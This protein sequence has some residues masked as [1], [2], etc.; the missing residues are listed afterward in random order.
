[1]AGAGAG[2]DGG[3]EGAGG[4]EPGPSNYH[5]GGDAAFSRSS[6]RFDGSSPRPGARDN[7]AVRH[8][9]VNERRL[10]KALQTPAPGV[11]AF[12]GD[13]MGM[14]PSSGWTGGAGKGD[15]ITGDHS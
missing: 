5:R 8:R 11:E 14:Q 15:T 9:V 2:A 7:D 6:C 4:V 3:G 12:V 1:M 13:G 10:P